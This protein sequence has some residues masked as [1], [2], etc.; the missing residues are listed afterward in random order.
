MLEYFTPYLTEE[1]ARIARLVGQDCPCD[2]VGSPTF[3]PEGR[4]TAF[5]EKAE[6]EEEDE[7]ET[8]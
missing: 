7:P 6:E 5:V 2:F 8:Q 3:R 4:N 1:E